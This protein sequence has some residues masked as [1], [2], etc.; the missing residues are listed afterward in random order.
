[1]P[2]P[3]GCAWLHECPSHLVG[4]CQLGNSCRANHTAVMQGNLGLARGRS[5]VVL[6]KPLRV[7]LGL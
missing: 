3:E 7:E 5:L 4:L 6:L 1:M 2:F